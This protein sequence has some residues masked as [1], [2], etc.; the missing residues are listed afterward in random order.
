MDNLGQLPLGVV[1]MDSPNLPFSLSFQYFSKLLMIPFMKTT[2]LRP[3]VG[4][5]GRIKSKKADFGK[6]GF[7]VARNLPLARNVPP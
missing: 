4:Y 7:T 3:K 5:L 1:G 6:I 2:L